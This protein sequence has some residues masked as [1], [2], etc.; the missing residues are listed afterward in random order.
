MADDFEKFDGR[1]VGHGLKTP[2][3]L[4][5]EL[6]RGNVNVVSITNYNRIC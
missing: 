1:A 5:F 3:V 6:I 2:T 4:K